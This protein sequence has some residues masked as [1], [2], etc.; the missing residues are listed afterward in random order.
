MKRL[1][2]ILVLVISIS[3]IGKAQCPA[4]VSEFAFDYAKPVT[5]GMVV[6]TLTAC[7][8]DNGQTVTWSI[9]DAS[10]FWAVVD[11]EIRAADASGINGSSTTEYVITVTA[12]DDG[13][14]PESSSSVVTL[15]EVN[16]APVAP[17][18]QTFD[19]DENM[20][21]GTVVGIIN[22]I[23]PN[24]D[25]LT[26]HV[27]EWGTDFY[28][29]FSFVDGVISTKQILNYEGGSTVFTMEV[30]VT[31]NGSPELSVDISV[32]VSI[33]DVNEPP[34]ISN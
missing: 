30:T 11:G 13:T 31:D 24:G 3:M 33:N 34:T 20:P 28:N 1:L 6:G 19:I 15:N 22:V 23:D 8:P 7:D 5:N 32:S 2:G 21:I 17:A 26:Y 14:T 12:T 25:D 16:A 18:N 29:L 10:G 9:S 27:T 4:H